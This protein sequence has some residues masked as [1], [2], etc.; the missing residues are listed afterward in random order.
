MPITAGTLGELRDVRL[1]R[2]Q[3]VFLFDSSRLVLEPVLPNAIR[4]TWIPAHWRLYTQPFANAYAV[5]ERVWPASAVQME[6][7]AGCVRVHAGAITIEAERN[8][9]R[10]RYLDEAG[11]PL[12]EEVEGGG[13]S[14]SYWEYALRYRLDEQEHFYGLGQPD[15]TGARVELDHRGSRHEIFNRHLPPATTVLPAVLAARGYGLLID[16]PCRA[17]WDF[18]YEDSGTF[19]YQARGGAL[20]YYMFRAPGLKELLRTYC[21][22]TGYPVLPP[23]W[24]FGLLQSR[25]GYRNRTELEAIAREFR[26]R[27]LPCDALVL[28]LYWFAQMGDLTF[29]PRAW[30]EPADMLRKLKAQGLRTIVIEE[31]YVTEAS[32]NYSVTRAAGYLGR[33]Y[34]GSPYT[35]DFW[36]GQCALL[37]FTNPAARNWWT[38]QHRP[39]LEMGIDGWWA[40]LNEPSKHPQDM[41]HHGG[42]AEAVHN[43]YP[44]L[45]QQAISAAYERYAPGRRAFILSR[46]AYAGAQRYGVGWWSGDVERTF[47]ALRKQVAVGLSAGLAGIPLWSSDVGGYGFAGECTPELYVRWFQFGAFTPLLRPH[48]DETQKRE[49]WQFGGQVEAIC[50]TYLRLRYRLLPYIYTLAQEASSSGTP[51]MRP[52]IMEFPGDAVASNLADQYLFGPDILVAPVTEADAVSR[53]VY[54]PAATWSD[55]W[56][57]ARVQ[58]PCTIE[59]AAP[60]DRLPL[61]IREGAIV[62][63]GPDLQYSGELP[64]DPLTLAIYPAPGR[65]RSFTLYEDDGE[66][67]DYRAGAFAQTRFDVAETDGT[68]RWRAGAREGGLAIPTR[69]LLLE[70][71]HCRQPRQANWAGASLPAAPSLASLHVMPAGAFWHRERALMIVK[72]PDNGAPSSLTLV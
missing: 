47:A 17:R 11:R 53:P 15:Q 38:E 37:D 71:H 39:L 7:D 45:M 57:G 54:L 55:F 68:I 34:D 64:L 63:M 46:S 49:P 35:F 56:T 28:D 24:V 48:G 20:Q 67:T 16:N 25:Y 41:A 62:P 70:F 31:P 72:L 12:L 4:H 43:L 32:R 19:S 13:L 21:E 2:A 52:V 50:R 3:A 36:P 1:E 22:L 40:D 59:A 42:S 14:W 5:P 10:L 27:R 18:G 6:Q 65:T 9:F 44:L 30:P 23:R 60:L 29:D 58:G 33:H 51:L 8:P 69:T 26:A 61:Y 66:S